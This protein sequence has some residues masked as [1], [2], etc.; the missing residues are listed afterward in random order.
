M[1]GGSSTR[2]SRRLPISGEVGNLTHLARG[3][4]P[5]W[6]P[7]EPRRDPRRANRPLR[8]CR[9][10]GGKDPVDDFAGTGVIAVGD[11]EGGEGVG[12][13]DGLDDD[14]AAGDAA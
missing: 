10:K 14:T 12:P 1:S 9:L 7:W 4:P 8:L 11:A 6:L 5:R 2:P 3:K 13:A